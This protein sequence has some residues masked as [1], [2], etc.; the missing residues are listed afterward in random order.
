MTLFRENYLQQ[1]VANPAINDCNSSSPF[2]DSNLGSCVSCP[3]Q[4][5]YFNLATNKCQDC[6]DR[7]YNAQKFMCE[8]KSLDYDPTL[9][10][11]VMNII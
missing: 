5:P 6:G 7:Q 4:Y 9:S 10:R 8:P 11:L 3:Q 1:K 2:F